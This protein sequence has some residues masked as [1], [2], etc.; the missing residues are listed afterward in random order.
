MGDYPDLSQP[1]KPAQLFDILTELAAAV[2]RKRR[3]RTA[4]EPPAGE[5]SRLQILMAEDN[6]VN[7]KVA[8]LMLRNL[9][10]EADVATNGVEVLAAIERRS[11]DMILMD[12]QMPE[13]D[14][15]EATR[16]IH[17]S[18]AAEQRPTIIAMTAHALRGYREKCLAAGMD[19]YISKPI[20]L[21]PLQAILRRVEKQSSAAAEPADQQSEQTIGS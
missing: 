21:E 19:D 8:L 3:P 9:G 5:R 10:Y 16:L 11:Y 7:L 2:P 15:F 13:M 6:P 18:L 1:V 14:G 4:V 17:Q 12:V 20:K